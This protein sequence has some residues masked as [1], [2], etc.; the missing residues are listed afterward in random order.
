MSQVSV[1]PPGGPPPPPPPLPGLPSPPRPPAVPQRLPFSA[2]PSSRCLRVCVCG[3][4]HPPRFLPRLACVGGRPPHPPTCVPL[5]GFGVGRLALL[6]SPACAGPVTSLRCRCMSAA[7]SRSPSPV[8]CVCRLYN[9]SCLLAFL[10]CARGAIPGA[11]DVVCV[12]RHYTAIVVLPC[13]AVVCWQR[14]CS[15]LLALLA[16]VGTTVAVTSLYCSRVLAVPSHLPSPMA[17]M[18][19]HYNRS[20]LLALQACWQR[21]LTHLFA[22]LACVGG[23]VP[24]ATMHCL[25]G[26]RKPAIA[27]VLA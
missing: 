26:S 25:R 20:H 1:P 7:L 5:R 16:C 4:R 13:V 23:A 8:V 22:L 6:V 27:L 18:R 14:S 21:S 9:E 10:P 17:C 3:Q 2:V 24:V 11:R 19:R 12:R 15:R